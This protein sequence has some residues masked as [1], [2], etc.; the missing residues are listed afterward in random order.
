MQP[1]SGRVGVAQLIQPSQREDERLL[2]RVCGIFPADKEMERVGVES[3]LVSD[4]RCAQ[5][6][7]VAA[8]RGVDKVGVR[9]MLIRRLVH[10]HVNKMC[11]QAKSSTAT[12]NQG[13]SAY[14]QSC[15]ACKRLRRLR[16]SNPGGG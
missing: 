13:P 7:A 11:P 8:S 12:S 15:C 9:R 16:D 4:E 6:Q 14:R 3:G 1:G 5:D 10:H 2:D